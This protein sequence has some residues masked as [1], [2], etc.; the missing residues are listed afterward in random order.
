MYPS[1][2][3]LASY[4]VSCENSVLVVHAGS[5]GDLQPDSAQERVEVGHDA[6]IESVQP[7]TL[8]VGEAR[9]GGDGR[10]QAGDERGVYPFEELQKDDA[11]RVALGE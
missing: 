5:C 7:L 2:E 10:E 4:A 6:L 8:V 9:I 3:M 11:D 1:V